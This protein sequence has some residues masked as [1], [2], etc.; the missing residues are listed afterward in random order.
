V[1]LPLV[2]PAVGALLL[3][4]S[5]EFW[6]YSVVAEVFA[7]NNLFAASL[8]LLAVEWAR[9]PERRKL[10]WA[11]ALIL[12][13]ALSNQQTIVLLG[14][15]F[16][17]FA[18]SGVQTLRRRRRRGRV[19]GG[20]RLR[21]ADLA[22]AAG[23]F[24]VGLLPYAYLPLAARSNPVANWGNPDTF[25]RFT[26]HIFRKDYGTLR[27]SAGGKSGSIGQNLGLL[28]SNLTTGFVV[29]GVILAAIGLWWGWRNR[30]SATVALALAFLFA[31]PIFVAYAK[32]AFPDE[33]TKGVVARF[34]ILPS[35]PLAV[36]VGVGAWL[37]LVWAQRLRRPALRP[38]VV[39]AVVAGAL[40]A[41]P[42][43]SAVVHFN[44]ENHSGDWVDLR[45][46]Q[47]ILG[48]LAPNAILLER[49][50]ENYT[51]TEYAQFV[52]HFRPDV[53]ALDT[54]Q[55]KSASYVN[56]I[57]RE[58]PS[59][60][61]PFENY[62]AGQTNSLNQLVQANIDQRPVYAVGKMEEKK[63][64]QGFD[65]EWTGLAQRLLP[66]GTQPDQYA[67]LRARAN[68]FAALHYPTGKYRASSW[69]ET[70]A[71]DY[72]RLAINLGYALQTEH[73]PK[74]APLAERMLRTA[75]RLMPDDKSAAPAYKNLGL[76][77]FDENADPKQIISLW[78][79]F[80]RLDPSDPQAPAI[81]T[82]IAKL[83][84]RKGR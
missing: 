79:H 53:V 71:Q 1:W 26:N 65:K 20:R 35:I 43:A 14:P 62:T 24:V 10:L 66:Q 44:D 36:L 16:L 9:H 80:L 74:V 83:Q 47:D 2:A 29:V 28:A 58:H 57:R 63:F 72:G 12:G 42:V 33:L 51:A 75:I 70:I 19:E 73:D 4:F 49:G 8:L 45:Y 6:T 3:A 41:V 11:F 61:I 54:E 38:I 5:T 50:D 78:N 46:A 37:V 22:I 31:G 67:D 15:A 60:V 34:Y 59:V 39:V 82:Q 17:V 25:N 64:G 48:P 55:L 56:Q 21:I 23:L 68:Q 18:W 84:A 76:L 32:S 81:R 69:E 40:L 13:L 52:E 27:L 30:R 7:L 77:L